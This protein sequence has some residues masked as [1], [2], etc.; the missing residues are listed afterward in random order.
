MSLIRKQSVF[1][2]A[3]S[4]AKCLELL[5]IADPKQSASKVSEVKCLECL[6]I[7][8]RASPKTLAQDGL[9]LLCKYYNAQKA[10]LRARWRKEEL[11]R[12]IQQ[13]FP[14]FP[15]QEI[16]PRCASTA[17]PSQEV[18][19]YPEYFLRGLHLAKTLFVQVQLACLMLA[20][21]RGLG[22]RRGWTVRS[23]QHEPMQGGC[24]SVCV[25]D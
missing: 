1:K 21:L 14:E 15:Q 16:A 10:N 22:L 25:R 5:P 9:V 24:R 8:S 17:P 18:K 6:S 2:D 4:K 3:Q 20:V 12:R 13:N 23:I 7:E 11:P 19:S